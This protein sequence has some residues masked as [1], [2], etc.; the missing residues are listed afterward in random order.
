MPGVPTPYL[1]LIDLRAIRRLSHRRLATV[2]LQDVQICRIEVVIFIYRCNSAFVCGVEDPA[3]V[4][5]FAFAG[6]S[7]IDFVLAGRQVLAAKTELH[8]VI[9]RAARKQL[10]KTR[11]RL[12][13]Q[14]E[15]F[16]HAMCSSIWL[17]V[18]T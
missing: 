4:V 8:V 18:L 3:R 16:R 12:R 11:I 7:Q 17:L 13:L 10:F 14:L 1:V 2:R 5:S 15:Y 9:S 6:P